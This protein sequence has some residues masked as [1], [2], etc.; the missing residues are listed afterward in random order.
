MKGADN[1]EILY[2]DCWDAFTNACLDL[3]C[4]W[5]AAQP[6]VKHNNAIIEN[7]NLQIVYDTKVALSTAGLPACFWPFAVV[8]VCILHNITKSYDQNGYSMCPWEI[9]FGEE[10]QGKTSPFGCGLFYLPAPTKGMNTKAAPNMS[11]GIFLGY[12]TVPGGNWTGQYI[13]ADIEAF[14]GKS[15]GIDEPGAQYR[16]W[17]HFT[18][19]VCLGKRGV[20]FPLKTKYDRLAMTID[21]VDAQSDQ[22][23]HIEV[24]EFGVTSITKA[25]QTFDVEVDEPTDEVRAVNERLAKVAEQTITDQVISEIGDD[26]DIPALLDNSSSEDENLGESMS[27]LLSERKS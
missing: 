15:L 7:T 23:A 14:I 21:G 5:Q 27:I 9:K 25:T 2:S 8:Y 18:E 6:G 24:D 11:Y 19:Q 22:T 17:P 10:F 4:A 12:R 20:C 1:W 3:E 13:V 16:I 26:S